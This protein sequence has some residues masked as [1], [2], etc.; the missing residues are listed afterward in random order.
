MSAIV[1]ANGSAYRAAASL[2]NN[3]APSAAG[4]SAGTS[5]SATSS[6]TITS[7]D[8]VDL[9]ARAKQLLA[10]AKSEQ[11]AVDKLDALLKSLIKPDSETSDG[12][13][14]S[15]AG[16]SLFEQLSGRTHQKSDTNWT[17]GARAGDPSISD[18]DF[19][20]KY[21]DTLVGG[22]EGFP[23]EKQAALQAA[24]SNGTLR[25]QKGADVSGYNTQT[26]ITYSV[27]PGGGQ[28]MSTSG[29]MAPTGAAKEAIQAGNAYGF[30]TEDRGDVYVTW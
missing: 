1:A 24:I 17:A 30:W 18:A 27:G 6:T 16:G 4:A 21:K 14:E 2:L 23:P 12:K 15:S 26:A 11:G 7:T 25:F 9:S 10:R 3:V 19:I 20:A 29:Y 8:T 22:L 28:G 13:P 5:E